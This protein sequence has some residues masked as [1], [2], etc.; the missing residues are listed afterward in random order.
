MSGEEQLGVDREE[1]EL[2]SVRLT[3]SFK[4]RLKSKAAKERRKLSD[5]VR[6]MLEQSLEAEE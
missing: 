5:Q 2:M 4:E 3:K 6:L 1:Y